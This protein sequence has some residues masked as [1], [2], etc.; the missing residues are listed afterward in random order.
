MARDVPDLGQ[1]PEPNCT[2][3]RYRAM[4]A[5]ASI[6]RRSVARM[7]ATISAVPLAPLG[8]IGGY[9]GVGSI[10]PGLE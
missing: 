2:V 6:P 4:V 1:L 8:P 3:G 5:S 9:F 7:Q 10:G